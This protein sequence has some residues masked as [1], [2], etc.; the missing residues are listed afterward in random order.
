MQPQGVATR[1]RLAAA[2]ALVAVLTGL[3][4]RPA[5]HHA[6]VGWDDILYF[7]QVQKLTG[8][9][10]AALSFA[11]TQLSPFYYHPL[12]WMSHWLEWQLWGDH[13]AAHH[14]VSIGIHSINAGLV[15]VLAWQLF[16]LGAPCWT[17]ATWLVAASFAGLVFGV[18]PLQV[19]SVAWLAGRKNLLCGLFGI[20][21]VMVYVHLAPR[22]RRHWWLPVILLHVLALASKPMA[23]PMPLVLLVLDVFP[24]RRHN[25]E[26]LW[27]LAWEKWPLIVASLVSAGLSSIGQLDWGAVMPA[28]EFGLGARFLVACRG[29]LFGLWKLCWPAWLS[30]LYPLG[31][32]LRLA[33]PDFAVS[34]TVMTMLAGCAM[35]MAY[36]G[37]PALAVALVSYAALVLPT[38]G[39]FQVGA[40]AAADRFYY[41]AL[42]GPVLLTVAAVVHV[43]HRRAPWLRWAAVGVGVMVLV[44]L[45]WRT[46]QQ[47][48]VWQNGVTLWTH[49]LRFYPQSGSTQFRLARALTDAGQLD[50]A[51]P[52]AARAARQI[53]EDAEVRSLAGALL[54]HF[55]RLDEARAELRAALVLDPSLPAA[56]FNLARVEARRGDSRAAIH[57]LHRLLQQHPDFAPLVARDA[58]LASYLTSSSAPTPPG[59]E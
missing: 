54:L 8:G 14:T 45:G 17:P 53:P 20:L 26:P 25:R 38:S 7:E 5:A 49:V 24:L 34:V 40:Q 18:H 30:P 41:L 27:R 32:E 3:C 37:S 57:H 19:E 23:V 12:T 58:A 1:Y 44:A 21:T 48:P 9:W 15:T 59:P 46:R 29:L 56:R 36:R 51:L 13:W 42:F 28:I 50:V 2:A 35:V 10:R 11:T 52:L 33:N 39:L 6:I 31:G 16:G 22:G 55:G 43:V 47:I 4:Y